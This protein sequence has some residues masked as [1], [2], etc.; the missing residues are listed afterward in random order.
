MQRIAFDEQDAGLTPRDLLLSDLQHGAAEIHADDGSLLSQFQGEIA[1][2]AAEIE[3]ERVRYRE[4]G[5]ELTRG[6]TS[7][8]TVHIEGEH[9]VEQIVSGCDRREHAADALPMAER[10]FHAFCRLPGDPPASC[11][12]ALLCLSH[13][14]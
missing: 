13:G 3:N 11:A 4:M 6:E 2:A 14:K 10:E 1:R 5:A 8:A 7:P 9:V 12:L